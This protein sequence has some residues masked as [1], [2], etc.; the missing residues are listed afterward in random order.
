[1]LSPSFSNFLHQIS[2]KTEET[3][4]EDGWTVE[5][6]AGAPFTLVAIAKY[7]DNPYFLIFYP[8]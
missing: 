5:I 7:F 1:M 3:S 2:V 8:N 4:T 6:N